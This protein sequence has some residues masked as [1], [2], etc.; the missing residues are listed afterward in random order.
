[1]EFKSKI[2]EGINEF[3][4]NT[5]F[6]A[7]Y[8]KCNLVTRQKIVSLI[9]DDGRIEGTGLFVIIRYDIP[10]DECHIGMGQGPTYS[11]VKI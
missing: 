1:M 9:N 4:Q 2:Q 6:V 5:F 8:L 10:D 3:Q 7:D 11:T